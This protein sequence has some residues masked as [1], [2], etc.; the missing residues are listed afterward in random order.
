M[1]SLYF[2]RTVYKREASHIYLTLSCTFFIVM[3]REGC[4]LF[5]YLYFIFKGRDFFFF[6]WDALRDFSYW[7]VGHYYSREPSRKEKECYMQVSKLFI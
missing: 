3:G 6:G 5:P 4:T 1:G 7:L 2:P